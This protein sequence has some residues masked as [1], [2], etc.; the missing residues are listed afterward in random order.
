MQAFAL[1]VAACLALLTNMAAQVISH[2]HILRGRL[3]ATLAAGF[4]VGFAALLIMCIATW[5]LTKP[6]EEFWYRFA[7]A[8]LIYGAGSFAFLC[9]VA[10]AETSVRIELLR[11][12]SA[13]PDG[14]TITELD[15]LYNDRTLFHMRLDRLLEVGAIQ[16][17]DRY[18][19]LTSMSLL[20]VARVFLAAK[21]LI[22]GVTDEFGLKNQ[23]SGLPFRDPGLRER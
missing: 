11:Q 23:P 6:A 8:V 22:F 2:R 19:R 4:T 18:Y 5:L 16:K 15:A 20:F 17:V 9:L 13:H 7:S 12:L 1:I 14:L 10:A 21:I 3:A